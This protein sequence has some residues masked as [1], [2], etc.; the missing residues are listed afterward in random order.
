MACKSQKWLFLHEYVLR[1]NVH[2]ICLLFFCV[3]T[4]EELLCWMRCCCVPARSRRGNRKDWAPTLEAKYIN[5][6]IYERHTVAMM[7]MSKC[8]RVCSVDSDEP[9]FKSFVSRTHLYLCFWLLCR[10]Q[11]VFA[12]MRVSKNKREKKRVNRL[13]ASSA[14]YQP[15][16]LEA[17]HS[18]RE[19]KSKK[20]PKE[21][22][23]HIFTV[24]FFSIPTRF[25]ESR[26][27]WRALNTHTPLH[28]KSCC[29]CACWSAFGVNKVEFIYFHRFGSATM[30][31]S[32]KKNRE[33]AHPEAIFASNQILFGMWVVS[34][35]ISGDLSHASGQ[36]HLVNVR[37]VFESPDRRLIY[38][39]LH[40]A[41]CR[42]HFFFIGFSSQ[43]PRCQHSKRKQ[44]IECD[45][46]VQMLCE[47]AVSFIRRFVCMTD[48]SLCNDRWMLY[49]IGVAQPQTLVV[50]VQINL[51]Q[52]QSRNQY[53]RVCVNLHVPFAV[54][55][56]LV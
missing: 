48:S 5:G 40:P 34:N 23:T 3:F 13:L 28:S 12:E 31:F 20:Q 16:K 4:I 18:E 6:E 46:C 53:L 39:C 21:T 41:Y 42:I 43:P 54:H 50:L 38:M 8:V 22:L 19:Y 56:D 1:G 44:H 55:Y 10:I 11:W 49:F 15:P 32:Y 24:T 47:I 45:E 36:L 33:C 37:K 7:A 17:S 52:I 9:S 29:W 30:F 25:N 26:R 2:L 51:V 14:Q 27:Y 35:W